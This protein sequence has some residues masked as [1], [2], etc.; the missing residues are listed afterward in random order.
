MSVIGEVNIVSSAMNKDKAE[1]FNK[2][3][4]VKKV[5]D[6]A[7]KEAKDLKIQVIS[8]LGIFAGIVVAFSFSISTIG[9]ALSNLTNVNLLKV[10]LIIFVLGIVFINTISLLMIFVA[11]ISGFSLE[12]KQMWKAYKYINIFLA[13]GMILFLILSLVFSKS[14]EQCEQCQTELALCNLNLSLHF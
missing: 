1:M 14:V 6:E 3:E 8:I 2:V 7:K 10:A 11:K 4:E 12:N 13:L 5:F 9:E